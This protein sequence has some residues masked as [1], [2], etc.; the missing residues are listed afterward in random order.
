VTKLGNKIKG[1]WCEIDPQ[2]GNGESPHPDPG[3]L[4]NLR[5]WKNLWGTGVGV[6]ESALPADYE[7]EC[8]IN[9]C[10]RLL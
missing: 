2:N 6:R 1:I 10:R 7:E 9:L 4:L 3:E 8:Q 5:T